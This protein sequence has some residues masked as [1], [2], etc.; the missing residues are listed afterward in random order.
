MLTFGSIQNADEPANKE[1]EGSLGHSM[2]LG[3]DSWDTLSNR[4]KYLKWLVEYELRGAR[5]HRRYATVLLA[6]SLPPGRHFEILRDLFRDCD[7]FILCSPSLAAILLRETSIDGAL[8]VIDRYQKICEGH[9]ELGFA[10]A[11]YPTDG[12]NAAVML[13]AAERRLAQVRDHPG[14]LVIHEG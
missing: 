3:E 12:V 5:R 11:T 4:F 13:D 6:A 10:L 1:L 9:V 7:E 2:P 8:A 14:G